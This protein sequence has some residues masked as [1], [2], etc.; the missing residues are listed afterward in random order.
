MDICLEKTQP[1]DVLA[2]RGAFHFRA[3]LR[4]YGLRS[5]DVALTAGVRYLVV[6][7]VEHGQP[8]QREQAAR[9]RE[10]LYALTGVPFTVPLA[11]YETALRREA[12]R[13]RIW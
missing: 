9:I 11:L 7:K 2:I 1:L 6:W 13:S 5:L 10:G 8:V 4:R 12:S 3:Y